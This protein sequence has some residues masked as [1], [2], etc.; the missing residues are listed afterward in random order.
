MKTKKILKPSFLII[1]G[2]KCASSSLYRYLNDHPQVLPCRVKEPGY[3]NFTNPLVLLKK[4]R[5]Y[6]NKFPDLNQAKAIGDWI[7]LEGDGTLSESKF[8]KL[9][10]PDVDYITG[11][12]TATTMVRANPKIVKRIFPNIKIIALVRNP[13]DR[14]ISHFQMFKRYDEAGR[15]GNN[16]GTLEEFITEE[17]EAHESNKK[18]RILDHGFYAQQLLKWERTF[19]E[20]LRVIHSDQLQDDNSVATMDELTQF[21]NLQDHD[22]SNILQ[23]RFNRNSKPKPTN[24][25]AREKLDAIYHPHNVALKEKYGIDFL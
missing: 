13:T 21:L 7:E 12:A 23:Q 8:E 5:S 14:F 22:F 10:H 4:Y 19:D 15:K 16:V 6:I 11:E 25:T 18:T 2:V 17:I 20:G 3:F 1:G 9:I 24:P